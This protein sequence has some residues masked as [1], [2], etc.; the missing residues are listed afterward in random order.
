MK[1]KIEDYSGNDITE[2]SFHYVT[3]EITDSFTTSIGILVS[4]NNFEV[5]DIV[6]DNDGI[7]IRLQPMDKTTLKVKEL[8][9]TLFTRF[10]KTSF[11]P[12][13]KD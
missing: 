6:E 11:E 12:Y 2:I 7:V 3:N 4:L 8:L 1:F 9:I 13:H 10:G 5:A